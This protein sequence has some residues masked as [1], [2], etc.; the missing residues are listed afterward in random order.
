MDASSTQ[1]LITTAVTDFGTSGLVIL[2]AVI[3]IALALL[4]FR[5]GWKKLRGST[6]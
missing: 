4:V 2:G 1:A 3:G 5:F 6:H